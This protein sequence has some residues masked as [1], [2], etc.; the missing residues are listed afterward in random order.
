MSFADNITPSPA[1]RR[2]HKVR[3]AILDAAETVFAQHGEAGLS[4]RKLADAIDYSPAAIYK[5]FGS[6]TE[7]VDELKEAFFARILG[8]IEDQ[9]GSEKPFPEKARE[10]VAVYVSTALEKPHHYAAA[11][12]G[13]AEPAR[14]DDDAFEHSNKARAFDHLASMVAD[15]QA[16]GFFRKDFDPELAA[17]SV[18]AASHGL[19]LMMMH[20][21]A[22]PNFDPACGDADR[23]GFIALHAD[24]LV[25]GLEK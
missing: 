6:K 9:Q 3:E 25:R 4:I 13:I 8:C 15:G 10:C 18:W 11:F 14:Q 20:M 17:K 7:L 24:F 12:S 21:P 22:F 16:L 2:R 23:E 19:A 5:Y 1:E